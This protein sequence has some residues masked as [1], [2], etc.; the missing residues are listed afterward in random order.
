MGDGLAGAERSSAIHVDIPLMPFR[1]NHF[2][3][4]QLQFITISTSRRDR[5]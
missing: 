1:G 2:R 5:R 3:P 4:G